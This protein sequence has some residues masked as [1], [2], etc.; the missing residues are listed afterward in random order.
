MPRRDYLDDPNAPAANLDVEVTG[1]VGIYTSPSHVMAYDDGE[2]RQQFSVCFTTRLLGG[3]L[4][5]SSET[6]EVCFV[7]PAALESLGI[8]PSMRLRIDHH[9]EHRPAP[10]IG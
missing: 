5:T 2:V 10:H 4:S 3:E 9:L 8:H 6:S 1:L 7:D